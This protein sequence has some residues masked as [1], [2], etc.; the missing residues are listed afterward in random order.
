MADE[1]LKSPENSKQ[2]DDSDPYHVSLEFSKISFPSVE[3]DLYR[4]AIRTTSEGILIWIESRSK[5]QQWQ[6]TVNDLKQHEPAGV[7][8]P[9]DVV[10]EHMQV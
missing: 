1:I 2:S 7:S 8:L 4:A 3:D 10:V 9:D 5:R 6:T